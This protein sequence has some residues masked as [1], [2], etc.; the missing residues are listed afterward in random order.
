MNYKKSFF[1]ILIVCSVTAYF[2]VLHKERRELLT[3]ITDLNRKLTLEKT[4]REKENQEAKLAIDIQLSKNEGLM[5]QVAGLEKNLIANKQ[6][7]IN[8]QEAAKIRLDTEINRNK[9]LTTVA[10]KLKED[11]EILNQRNQEIAAKL[12]R[13]IKENRVAEKIEVQPD[14]SW[15]YKLL[16]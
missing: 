3:E 2:A 1:V 11:L 14:K 5:Q 16:N 9:E 10:D 7:R 6:A 13:S 15:L 8:E 12:E 4:E